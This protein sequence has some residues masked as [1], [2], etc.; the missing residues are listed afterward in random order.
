MRL[1]AA[2]FIVAAGPLSAGS[3][4]FTVVNTNDSGSG[5]LR[6]AIVN[7]NNTV[8]GTILFDI[9]GAGVH[10]IQ[11]LSPLPAIT[12]TTLVDGY[13]QPGAS[14]NTL[15]DGN[16]AVLLIEIDGTNLGSIGIDLQSGGSFVR[17]LVIN[18]VPGIA[19][20]LA[21]TGG[22]VATGNF[23]GTDAAGAAALPNETGIVLGSP[24]NRVGGTTAA[25]RNLVSGNTFNGLSLDSGVG[26]L[27]QGNFI[28]TNRGGTGP[29]PNGRAGVSLGF[30]SGSIGGSSSG[31]RNLLSGNVYGIEQQGGSFVVQGNFVG[32]DVTGAEA[33]ANSGAGII[34][35]GDGIV[36]G[37]AAAGEGNL[38]S[39]N[40]GDGIF[41]QGASDISV[42]GNRIGTDVTGTA[43]L[44]NRFSGIDSQFGFVFPSGNR[45]GSTLPGEGNI[46]AFNGSAGIAL[47]NTMHTSIRRN[48]IF[49]NRELNG[50]G[51][52]ID[53][54][55]DGVTP[56]DDGDGDSGANALL[57]FPLIRSVEAGPGTTRIQATLRGVP[58]QT[59]GIDFF[60]SSCNFRPR[61][62][63]QGENF[64]GPAFMFTD[65][66]GFA[67]ID[68]TYPVAIP[69]GA[70]VSAT[71]TDADDNT[72]E[73]SQQIVFAIAPA[74]GP[75]AGGSAVTI[76]GTNFD[77]AVA[78]TIGGLSPANLVRVSDV[79]LTAEAP[80]L[81]PGSLNDVVAVNPDTTTGTLLKGWVADFLDVP[82]NHQ[83]H[84]NVTRLVSNGV[85]V[86]CGGGNYCVDSP[87]I[88]A[89]MAV[90]L[91]RAR[92][93]FCFSPPAATG[94]VFPDVPA[95][96]IY[97]PW[98]EELQRQGLTAGCGGG[99]YCPDAPVTRAQMAVF[100]LNTAYGPGYAPPPATGTVFDDVPLGTFAVDWIED[101]V[102]RGITAGC[103]SQPPLY[104][105]SASITRGQMATFVV[106]AF[107]LQP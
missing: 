10:T 85:T 7:A 13:T 17:G 19:V 49:R 77:P 30:G 74:S 65:S 5:S 29:L 31:A 20:Q 60:W 64:L 3:T 42:Y 56:N 38:I 69:A 50:V 100:L 66:N 90:F 22:H 98:I 57:N 2:F 23:I 9:P 103:S 86:G 93:G 18:R 63:L 40:G 101:L 41:I 72:S 26:N 11:P 80:A 34:L 73:F 76:T 44:G 62:F 96:N 78:V 46:I 61:D 39:G 35:Y 67:E 70:P 105:P 36:V 43:P 87:T 82:A 4:V 102:G 107:N 37:G 21:G 94:T 83:F 58:D 33:I 55:H 12:G 16:D 75:P 53:L 91:I 106:K 27:V 47:S 84:A 45:I 25:D 8:N 32:T 52:G 79:E 28:G 81:A 1:A 48:R 24:G 99:N 104:C 15:P 88:R 14:P 6:A 89:Q 97:A 51:L 95:S 54:D 71:A 59:F 68:I 92:L